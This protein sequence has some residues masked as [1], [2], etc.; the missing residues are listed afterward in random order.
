MHLEFFRRHLSVDVDKNHQ[1]RQQK[2]KLKQS[3][4]KTNHT[5]FSQHAVLLS[6]VIG[7]RVGIRTALPDNR[8]LRPTIAHKRDSKTNRDFPVCIRI[9]G[10][11]RWDTSP[12]D[13]RGRSTQGSSAMEKIDQAVGN[14]WSSQQQ[15]RDDR[16]GE[17][18]LLR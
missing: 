13:Q 10:F 16:K 5:S 17:N 7:T 18:L 8:I 15:L 6:F 2:K 9:A 3:S 14:A 12:K 4:Q 1:Q 11:P